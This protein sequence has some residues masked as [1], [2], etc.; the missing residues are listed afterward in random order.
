M[1]EPDEQFRS[2]LRGYEP[3]QVDQRIRELTD[4]AAAADRRVEELT[5]MVGKLESERD[6]APLDAGPPPVPTFEH[7]GKRVGEILA[8]AD[9]EAASLRAGAQE[10]VEALRGR[11]AED[12]GR[13]RAEAD[14]YSE[15]RR[16]DADTDASRILGDA[17]R[18]AD[19]VTDAADRNAAARLQEAEAV[20]EEQ[21]ARA[22]KAAADFETTLAG[23]KQAAEAEFTLQMDAA[24]Q[25][26]TDLGAL[27]ERQR[28]EADD[29]LA[30]SSRRA[31]RLVE[32]AEQKAAAIVTEAKTAAARVRADSDRELAAATQRRDSINAQLANVRQ[33]LV[34]LTG[35]APV[36][37]M[38]E[39]EVQQA[40]ET[41]DESVAEAAAEPETP[42]EEPAQEPAEEK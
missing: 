26:H 41:A 13:I 36:A 7:L 4:R 34:T 39:P 33:M 25:R 16:R 11:A 20:Y 10:E 3:Q 24:Q 18:T 35:S 21:R 28:A 42:A 38:D 29:E 22:A 32:E 27:I 14:K 8:L 40:T 1:N 6:S 5:E 17:Q 2:V 9:E 23:R 31:A 30:E 15:G 37:F 19:E 12:S